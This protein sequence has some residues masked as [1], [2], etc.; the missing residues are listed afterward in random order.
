MPYAPASYGF[1]FNPMSLPF[2]FHTHHL[3]APAGRAIINVPQ[4]WILQ[5]ERFDPRPGALY[6]AG[7]HPWWTAD[8]DEVACMLRQLPTLLQHPQ[9]VALGECGLDALRGAPLEDQEA[10]FCRQ[11][12]LAEQAG[13]PV[14]LHVVRT[15]DRLLRLHKTLRPTTTWTVHGFRGKPALARQLLQAGLD[16]SFGA[17]RNEETYRLTPPQRRHDETDED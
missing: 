16:L 13:L 7:I 4:A 5:P 14:T 11:I 17:R 8:T 1:Y 3:D 9:V 2:D 10:T 6:S 12:A 15:F